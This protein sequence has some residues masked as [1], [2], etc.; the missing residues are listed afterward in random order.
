MP[1]SIRFSRETTLGKTTVKKNGQA[2]E[3]DDLTL[4]PADVLTLENLNKKINKTLNLVFYPP[5]N[6]YMCL[7]IKYEV[8]LKKWTIT[9]VTYVNRSQIKI[10]VEDKALKALPA[11]KNGALETVP[12]N[13]VYLKLYPPNS[14]MKLIAINCNN[15]W[16]ITHLQSQNGEVIISMGDFK[17]ATV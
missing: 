5:I 9:P 1:I 4:K 3:T 8:S 7:S 13:N 17:N 6:S 2:I 15:S 16:V 10:T 14:D 11:P 12:P